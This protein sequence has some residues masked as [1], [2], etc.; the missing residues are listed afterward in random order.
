[1]ACTPA[2]R[3]QRNVGQH[4]GFTRLLLLMLLPTDEPSAFKR[5]RSVFLHL[6]PK[7]HRYSKYNG[8]ELSDILR[9]T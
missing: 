5:R 9:P 6:M 1:V 7:R 4:A 8:T 2:G 3:A